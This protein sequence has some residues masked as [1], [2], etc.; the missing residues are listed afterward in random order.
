MI[1]PYTA[2]EVPAGLAGR[3]LV[4][5][6]YR[7][8]GFEPE[9]AV[10]ADLVGV[11]LGFEDGVR[12]ITWAMDGEVEALALL[13]E[14]VSGSASEVT[15]VSARWPVGEQLV[16]VEGVWQEPSALWALRLQFESCSIV[17]ALGEFDG[18]LRYLPD[19]IVVIFDPD[20]A[21]AYM[22]SPGW[23]G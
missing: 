1:A 14:A 10:D 5:V 19:E 18:A 6:A 23:G 20:V 11:I 22:I 15:D 3:H 7:H 8:I 9:G 2:R 13:D 4:S 17:V 12:S 21:G 16:S